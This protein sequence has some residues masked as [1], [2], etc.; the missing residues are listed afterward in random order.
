MKIDVEGAEAAVLRGGS[1]VLDRSRPR[2]V[3]VEVQE[4]T[5]RCR[6]APLRMSSG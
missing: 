6:R 4:A 1:A 2:L 3:L 5:L